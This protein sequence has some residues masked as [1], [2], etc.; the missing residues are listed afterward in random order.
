MKKWIIWL[1]FI[2]FTILCSDT[3]RHIRIWKGTASEK[4]DNFSLWGKFT[5]NCL[6][7]SILCIVIPIIVV[8]NLMSWLLP[9]YI[10]ND[11]FLSEFVLFIPLIVLYLSGVYAT[12]AHYIWRIKNISHLLEEKE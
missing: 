4:F 1:S 5:F 6:K 9:E 7:L 10:W 2:G 3:S 11:P 12:Y 8:A